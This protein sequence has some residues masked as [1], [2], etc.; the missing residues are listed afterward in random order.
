LLEQ[1]QAVEV[2]M[3][4]RMVRSL[5]FAGLFVS[6]LACSR[7]RSTRADHPLTHRELASRSVTITDAGGAPGFAD[8]L[9]QALA[10]EGF[11][12]VDHEPYHGELELTVNTRRSR[13]GPV[14]VATLRSDGFFVDEVR[15]HVEQ[16][17]A[18]AAWLAKS[19]AI[20]Q[21][22]ADFVRN[23]GTPSQTNFAK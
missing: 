18:A 17:D 14:A 4:R 20:S 19:L 21:G 7:Y 16:G 13:S 12:V 2:F 3:E 9:S 22:M 23:G 10:V 1:G 6:S 5:L 11:T 15:A 8:A